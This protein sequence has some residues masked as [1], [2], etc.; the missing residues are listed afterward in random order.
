MSDT[1]IQQPTLYPSF[2]FGAAG[3]HENI[4]GLEA[5]SHRNQTVV[6]QI[7]P[8]CLERKDIIIHSY[9]KLLKMYLF[10]TL[11]LFHSKY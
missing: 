3:N 6:K 1:V 11:I 4:S 8:E 2:G 7:R 5:L 9:Y 10:N